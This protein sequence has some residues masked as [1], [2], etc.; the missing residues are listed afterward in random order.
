MV[1]IH[2]LFSETLGT[3]VGQ[4]FVDF[5]EQMCIYCILYNISHWG[6][7]RHPLVKHINISVA[8]YRHIH[9]KWGKCKI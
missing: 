6:L 1:W 9:T 8:K 5:R 4:N 3:N 2:E 7:E